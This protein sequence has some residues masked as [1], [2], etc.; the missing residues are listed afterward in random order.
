MRLKNCSAQKFIEGLNGRKVICFG[1]GST[2]IEA[3][4]EVLKI[5]GLENHIAFF[6]D[7]DGKKNGMKFHYCER[8]FDI[9]G[10]NALRVI[11]TSKYV[12]L[13]TC[14]FYVE[15][16][17]QLKDM[18]E[19]KEIDCYMY[20][21]VC[22]YPDLDV[23][24]FFVNEINKAPYK[25]WRE[26]LKGLKL[27]DKHK[28][29]RCFIIGNG[30]SLTVE[31]LELLKNEVTFATN[32]IFK[33][34]PK[35][36]WRPTY[37]FCTDYLMYGLDHKEINSID[38][39]LR[40]VPIERSLAAGKIYDE[41]TYYNRVVNCVAVENGEIVR[42]KKYDFSEEIEDKVL[43]GQTVL[44]DVLQFAVYMGFQ[45]IYLLGLDH[46]Y[47]KEVLEDGTILEHDIK[48]DH[49]SKEYDKGLDSAIAVVAPLYAAEIAY[50]SAKEVCDAKG[51]IIRNATRGGKLEIFER[52]KL[53]KALGMEE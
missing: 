7:N 37:Y 46:S 38:A 25:K 35:T 50:R 45:E 41:I 28:G 40:F 23:N 36:S 33:L 42:I 19:L 48:E 52:I 3:E 2:L 30:P 47:R 18:P 53:E 26:I 6:V 1:A 34:F 11:D 10:V 9:K 44:F 39:E 27:K 49:F 17:E 22:S 32:R 16:Y 20:N 21:C 4:Y 29:E 13:I 14:A 51:I 31:D 15:I 12:L 5:D 24:H 43:G 8:V